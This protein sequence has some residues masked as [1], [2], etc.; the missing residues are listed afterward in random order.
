MIT[1]VM[2]YIIEMRTMST[3]FQ[4]NQYQASAIFAFARPEL[5]SVVENMADYDVIIRLDFLYRR[6]LDAVL[7]YDLFKYSNGSFERSAVMDLSKE[8]ENLAMNF[9]ACHKTLS[10]MGDETRQHI[11]LEMMRMDYRGSRV[12]DITE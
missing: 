10:A 9:E 1:N 3:D 7:W 2:I 5:A 4:K 8:I 6:A 12:P 11:I